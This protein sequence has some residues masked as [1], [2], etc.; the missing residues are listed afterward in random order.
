MKKIALILSI[1]ALFVSVGI[2]KCEAAAS[3]NVVEISEK[4]MPRAT[5]TSTNKPI[6]KADFT[7]HVNNS[8]AKKEECSDNGCVVQDEIIVPVEP[9][10]QVIEPASKAKSNEKCDCNS[11][12]DCGENCTCNKKN[13]CSKDCTCNKKCNCSKKCDCAEACSCGKDGVNAKCKCKKCKAKSSATV[14]ETVTESD[15]NEASEEK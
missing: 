13:R 2:I 4:I 8:A 9:E 15:I 3:A 7:K 12:C 14:T 5:E 10:V 11:K 6:K 1:F